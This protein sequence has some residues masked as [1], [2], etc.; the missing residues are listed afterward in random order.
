VV[1]DL[2]VP[3][4]AVKE[5]ADKT[6]LQKLH[7]EG[8]KVHKTPTEAQIE[9]G[10]YRKGH[11]WIQGLN[12]TIENP[13]GSTRSGTDADGKTWSTTMKWAY[14]YIRGA[15]DAADADH[16]DVLIGPCPGV[17]LVYVIDQIKP[18]TKEWDE[19]KACIGFRSLKE[20]REGYLADYE[21]GWQ[22][23]GNITPLTMQQFKAWLKDGDLKRPI[24]EQTVLVKAAMADD[25]VD[26]ELPVLVIS[27]PL[28]ELRLV[29]P[30]REQ[31]FE[32]QGMFPVAKKEAV[33]A[34]PLNTFLQMADRLKACETPA[35]SS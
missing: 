33:L 6:I 1:A 13:K 31:P 2:P 24:A 25:D 4:L 5:A 7:H 35:E 17:E 21:Q 23:I 9:A 19:H 14:G 11:V 10:N 27:G 32:K 12:I 15:T 29:A 22:G 18:T 28:S 3:G 30:R 20:A 26:L 8:R 34:Y 16:L